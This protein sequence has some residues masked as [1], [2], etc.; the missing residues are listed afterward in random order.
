MDKESDV[1]ISVIIPTYNRAKI[2]P[3]AIK[4]VMRQTWSNIEIIIVDDGSTDNTPDV[5]SNIKRG[6]KR[7][8]IVRNRRRLGLPSARNIG[9]KNA[10][11][12]FVFFS[13]DD[14]ILAPNALE[15]LIKTFLSLS[16]RLNNWGYRSKNNTGFQRQGLH[17]S[18][19]RMRNSG[20]H[21]EI[22]WQN[23]RKLR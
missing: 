13:E 23:I 19:T 20:S 18:C 15:T 11:G 4:S 16:N 3:H 1:L 8:T 10:N 9:L 6:G 5:L 12:D 2:L 22:L 21:W 17:K 7:I 14:L